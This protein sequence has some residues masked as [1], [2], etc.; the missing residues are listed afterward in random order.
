MFRPL[1]A[2]AL[3]LALPLCAAGE[4]PKK[5]ININTATATELMQLPHVGAKTAER[6]I[7]FRKQNGG[8]KRVEEIMNVKGI[9]EKTF[10]KLKPLLSLGSGTPVPNS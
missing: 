9:G 4:L 5:P 2:L 1:L 8:F 7:A 6:I 10:A 3:S